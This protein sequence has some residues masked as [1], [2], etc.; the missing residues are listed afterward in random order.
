[1]AFRA[2]SAIAPT[3]LGEI[4]QEMLALKATVEQ[5]DSSITT[6]SNAD[7]LL[8]LLA[9][10]RRRKQ[11]LQGL[12]TTPGL[13]QYARDTENDQAYDV[14]AEGQAVL[15]LIESAYTTL[16]ALIPTDGNGYLLSHTLNAS[17]LRIP[18]SVG[19]GPLAGTRAALQAIA[20]A[21]E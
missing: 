14:V 19:A 18:R 7:Y 15:A 8:N 10:L 1:M 12:A 4:K 6:G 5:A 2:S 3:A 16:A 21:I 13:A 20:A 9:N 11:V 17:A